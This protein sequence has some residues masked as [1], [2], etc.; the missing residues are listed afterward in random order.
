[1][2]VSFQEIVGEYEPHREN[3]GQ[4]DDDDND[5][6]V[7]GKHEPHCGCRRQDKNSLLLRK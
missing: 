6:Q 7:D 3:G 4:D 5:N 2:E 1:M